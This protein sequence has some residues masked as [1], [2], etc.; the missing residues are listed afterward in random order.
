LAEELACVGWL[1][2][3]GSLG[4]S[5]VVCHLILVD[6]DDPEGAE[7]AEETRK[8]SE[9]GGPSLHVVIELA[10][11]VEVG[12]LNEEVKPCGELRDFVAGLRAL[13]VSFLLTSR[14]IGDVR[15]KLVVDV[16]LD[17]VPLD[18]FCSA[19]RIV[20]GLIDLHGNEESLPEVLIGEQFVTSLGELEESNDI[21]SSSTVILLTLVAHHS[22]LDVW[23]V[24][25][26]VC[27]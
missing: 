11:I 1:T 12:E 14:S 6:D 24:E 16:S 4:H 17:V 25:S 20:V 23:E 21:G 5:I 19:L 22:F 8:G 3:E 18:E 13:A 2:V 9:V 27:N 26:G 7:E 10:F 15:S